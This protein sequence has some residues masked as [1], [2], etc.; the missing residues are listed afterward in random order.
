L[1]SECGLSSRKSEEKEG[2]AHK[3]VTKFDR[4]RESPMLCDIITRKL[5]GGYQRK[6][7]N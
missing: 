2:K 6:R 1:S 3:S 5:I 7:A 4:G